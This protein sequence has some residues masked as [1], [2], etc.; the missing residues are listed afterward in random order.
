MSDSPG[1]SHSAAA[2]RFTVVR[3]Q[4]FLSLSC[5]C[6][7]EL[8][9]PAASLLPPTLSPLSSRECGLG[10]SPAPLNSPRSPFLPCRLPVIF[11]P[12]LLQQPDEG[13]FPLLLLTEKALSDL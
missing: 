7:S 3:L 8:P 4:P 9:Y 5:L 12:R 6:V 13:R 11:S 1:S 2:C 10:A